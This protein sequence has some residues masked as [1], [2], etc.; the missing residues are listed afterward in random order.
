MEKPTTPGPNPL[1]SQ[2]PEESGGEQNFGATGVFGVVKSPEPLKKPEVSPAPAP[3]APVYRAPEPPRPQPVTGPG[4]LAEPTVH[5]VV[6]GGGAAESVQELLERMRKATHERPAYAEKAPA[7]Q[8]GT[9]A[10]AGIGKTAEGN[11]T[12]LLQALAGPP[13]PPTAARPAPPPPPPPHPAQDSGFTSL[14]RTLSALDAPPAPVVT[15]VKPPQPAARVVPEEPKRAPA[16]PVPPAPPSAPTPGGFTELLRVAGSEGPAFGGAR[17]DTPSPAVAP[18]GGAPGAPAENKPGAFTQLFGTFGGAGATPSAPP[19]AAPPAPAENKPG[20][21]TQMFGTFGGAS[22]APPAP[23]P[24][25]PIAGGPPRGSV[26]SFTQM[27]SL[28]PQSAPA[29]PAWR[30]EPKPLAPAMD[31]GL[32]PATNRPGGQPS[33]SLDPF[34]SQTPEQPPIAATP[35]GSG[36]GITRLIQMLDEPSKPT[37]PVEVAPMSPGPGA[38]PGIWTQTFA[39]L[40]GGNEPAAPAAKAPEWTPPAAPAYAFAPPP[41]APA[42][43]PPVTASP[44]A[45]SRPSGPSEFTR[46]LDASRLREQAM[47]GGP[48]AEMPGQV[49]PPPGPGVAPPLPPMPQFAAPPP[50]PAGMQGMGGMPQPGAFPPP[51][52]PMAPG[53]YAMSYPPPAG[54]MA[55]PGGMPQPGMFAPP[56]MPAAPPAPPAKP[57]A[58]PA[59][60]LQ[61]ILLVMGAV[62]I[63][64][65]IVLIVVVIFMM[66]K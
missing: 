15:P 21:F 55:A 2:W 61:P 36:M 33:A 45:P 12:E 35:S 52:A 58:P 1:N 48:G 56:P 41:L 18:F 31:F 40:S 9:G 13:L 46:I 28:E 30:E 10:P 66:K 11:F 65:L 7:G 60:K 62:I 27:L 50:P 20:A 37:P 17:T 53:G 54:G 25:E 14:L 47:R 8:V 24:M 43:I 49:A 64:L 19:Q 51:Q 39:S 6:V 23:P 57:A 63:V 34:A 29:E 44:A 5:K 26:G 22:A 59:G 42:V 4:A 16:A 32:N 3:A 38:G